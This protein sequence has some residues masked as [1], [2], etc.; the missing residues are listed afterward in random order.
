MQENP[1]ADANAKQIEDWNGAVGEHWA[2]EQA[3]N[4]RR[5]KAF[6]EA[7]LRAAC[8]LPG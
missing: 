5:I 7:A 4:D 1:M 6:G 3:K 2:A 8:A